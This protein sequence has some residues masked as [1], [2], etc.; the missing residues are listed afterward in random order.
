MQEVYNFCQCLFGFVLPGHIGKCRFDIGVC[1]DLRSAA[2]ERHEISAVG[3]HTGPDAVGGLSPDE[4]EN[5]SRQYPHEY[6]IE[7]RRV[8]FRDYLV[9]RYFAVRVRTLGFQQPVYQLRVV[10]FSGLVGHD[11]VTF[12]GY[13]EINLVILYHDLFYLSFVHLFDKCSV[14]CDGYFSVGQVRED[15]PVQEQDNQYSPQEPHEGVPFGSVL[16]LCVLF[17]KKSASCL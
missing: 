14:I 8:F 5:Q 17:H 3:T 10:D 11:P 7:Y 1:V 12:F 15:K 16:V 9:E 4:V 13:R 6:E 2:S